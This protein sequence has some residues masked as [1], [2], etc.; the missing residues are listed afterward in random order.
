[1]IKV[2]IQEHES[3]AAIN[4][5]IIVECQEIRKYGRIYVKR[6]DLPRLHVDLPCPLEENNE[7]FDAFEVV[8][9]GEEY[10]LKH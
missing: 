6:S 4:G 8:Q 3:H 2:T 1:M 7:R 5:K 9:K 10:K